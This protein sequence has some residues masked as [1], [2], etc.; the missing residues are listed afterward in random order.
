MASYL[1]ADTSAIIPLRRQDRVTV[2]TISSPT[3]GQKPVGDP[4]GVKLRPQTRTLTEAPSPEFQTRFA[5]MSEAS[6]QHAPNPAP[7]IDPEK[8]AAEQRLLDQFIA[9]GPGVDLLGEPEE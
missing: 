6:L 9:E 1:N 2:I 8:I 4:F 5:Q 3:P 7:Y